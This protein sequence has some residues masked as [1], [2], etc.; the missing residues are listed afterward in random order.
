MVVFL[1]RPHLTLQGRCP[2]IC[3]PAEKHQVRPRR[4]KHVSPEGTFART[5]LVDSAS[6][7]ATPSPW[8]SASRTGS[9]EAALLSIVIPALNEEESIGSTVQ[10]CL[11]ARD[12]IQRFGHV[13]DVEIVVISDGSTDRTADIAIEI[14]A[15]EPAVRVIVF[16][17]NRGYGAAIKEGFSR[18]SGDLVGF[19]DADGTCD[20]NF[21]AELCY[22]IQSEDGSVALGSRMGADSAM[23]RVR[24]F[25]NTAYACLLGLLSGQSVSDTASGMRV[26]KRETLAGLYPLPD[27]LH[28]T[29]AMSARALMTDQRVVEI[30]MPYAERV[31]VSKLRVL[32]DGIRFLLSIRDAALLFRPA[33][34]FG[35][36]ALFCM[37]VGSAWSL[38][39]VEFYVRNHRLEEWMI[40]RLLLSGLLFTSGFSLICAGVLSDQLLSL[41]YE[42]KKTTFLNRVLHR[43]LTQ[44][45]LVAIA[46]LAAGVGV[47][48]V[49]P[50]LA[51]YAR[52]GHVTL[53]WSRPMVA[54]FLFQMSLFAVLQAALQKVIELWREQL[55]YAA[56]IG[57]NAERL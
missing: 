41:V 27:G 39:P 35:F 4:Y 38:F 46:S 40:Y 26:L 45:R 22:G 50:G 6:P 44:S 47:L 16:E 24:R 18:S 1:L 25:G 3:I 14:A 5:L 55:S 52:T 42:S 12:R 11:A 29:P 13:R 10:R 43:T 19:L 48:L 9:F 57:R 7:R 30:P 8:R 17:Q 49:W 31:G 28:F 33:R 32:R 53:H 15:R 54:V 51:E 21:F 20:P 34:L 23:P 2:S 56:S 36:A 37:V